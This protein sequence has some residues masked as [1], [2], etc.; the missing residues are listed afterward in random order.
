MQPVDG[1]EEDAEYDDEDGEEEKGVEF[2]GG[3]E[4][5]LEAAIGAL[6]GDSAGSGDDDGREHRGGDPDVGARGGGAVEECGA[7]DGGNGQE[8]VGAG[9]VEI[10]FDLRGE[11]LA[12]LFGIE[13]EEQRRE[14][15]GHVVSTPI[16]LQLFRGRAD[17]QYFIGRL[18]RNHFSRFARQRLARVYSSCS[19]QVE[20]RAAAVSQNASQ[21]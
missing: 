2:G 3:V 13:L 21:A 8:P 10:G 12:A 9:V 15:V 6:E 5:G 14:A 11:A 19:R 7:D 18:A 1:Q 17:C 16:E 20:K 4:F